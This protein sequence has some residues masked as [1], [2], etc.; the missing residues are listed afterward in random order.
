MRAPAPPMPR[1]QAM[2]RED[3]ASFADTPVHCAAPCHPV[4]ADEEDDSD[5]EG[6][7]AGDD[8]DDHDYEDDEKECTLQ[9]SMG[10]ALDT[11][12]DS[13]LAGAGTVHDCLHEAQHVL[14]MLI[15]KV[16]FAKH[17]SVCQKRLGT[18]ANKA[19]VEA[20]FLKRYDKSAGALRPK[21]KEMFD[22][23]R[24]RLP[25]AWRHTTP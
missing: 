2:V 5:R 18:S 25:G 21:D 14:D 19:D 9:S 12:A 3:A 23:V 8:D 17:A 24:G 10:L 4:D 15:T 1:L 16:E 22:V 11:M 6:E 7:G 13:L 20:Y